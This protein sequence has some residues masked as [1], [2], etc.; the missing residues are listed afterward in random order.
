MSNPLNRHTDLRDRLERL[1][2]GGMA[3]LF[4]ELALKAAKEGLTHEAYLY[5]LVKQEE[6]QRLQRRTERLLRQSS[7]PREKTFRTFDLKRLPAAWQLQVERLKQGTFLET[8]VN[9]IAVGKP[10][11]G[12]VT[13]RQHWATNSL[14]KGIRCYGSALQPWFSAS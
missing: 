1:N 9:V 6:E 5:E 13:S 10:G 11:V 8:A 14:C 12:K 2:L 3:A 4:A 7:L